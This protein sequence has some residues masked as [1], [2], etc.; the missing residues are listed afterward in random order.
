MEHVLRRALAEAKLGYDSVVGRGIA[1]QHTPLGRHVDPTGLAGY[2]FDLRHKAVDASKYADGIP[3]DALGRK[4]DWSIPVAQAALGYWEL[5]LEGHDFDRQFL[6]LA[7]W[8]VEN[9]KPAAGGLVWPC[10]MA[11]PKYALSPGWPSAMGQSEAISV[12]LRAEALSGRKHYGE[13]AHSGFAPL[14]TP[15]SAGGVARELDG[16]LVLEEYPTETPTAVLNGW[17]VS[18]LGIHELATVTGHADASALFDR[19]SEG[20]LRLLDRYDVGWWSLYS[21]YDH[22]SP[23]LAKP[24][25]QRFHPVL[26]RALDLVRPDSRFRAMAARWER[27]I[28]RLALLRV[29][30]NKVRF[31]LTRARSSGQ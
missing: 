11:V 13:V 6:A 22:G 7:D 26:L 30:A 3:R 20:L 28:T 8:L 4:A 18:L 25:Y 10:D 12:L 15:V 17:I 14:Q 21:L 19:S 16:Q 29:S 27:Q 5:R 2:Y 24:F 23:D 31:R 9:A 1:F